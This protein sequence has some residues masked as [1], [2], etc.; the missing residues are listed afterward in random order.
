[1]SVLWPRGNAV[2]CQEQVI[3]RRVDLLRRDAALLFSTLLAPL[4]HRWMQGRGVEVSAMRHQ[5]SLTHR[6]VRY[7]ALGAFIFYL[8]WN[9]AWI[10]HGRIP[11]SILRAAGGI[12]SPTTGGYRSFVAL[13]RGELVLSFLYNPMMLVYLSLFIYSMAVLFH[14]WIKRKRLVLHPY[15][16]WMWCASLLIGWAAKFAL[17]RQYW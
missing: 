17:G 6:I 9:V 14:Q 3:D 1:M 8:A 4:R 10:A 2:S 7:A 5:E 13:C 16:A 11:P 15:I 12:P